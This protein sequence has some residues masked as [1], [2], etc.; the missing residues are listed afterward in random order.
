M[1]SSYLTKIRDRRGPQD[2]GEW[3]PVTF[4]KLSPPQPA[5]ETRPKLAAS[6]VATMIVLAVNAFTASLLEIEA[7]VIAALALPLIAPVFGVLWIFQ[8]RRAKLEETILLGAVWGFLGFFA[9]AAVH[10][11]MLLAFLV[12]VLTGALGVASAWA[13]TWALDRRVRH[14]NA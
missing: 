2:S 1:Y 8:F 11:G 9:V 14:G 10:P 13:T 4:R 7:A 12:S 3:P 5:P 6:V